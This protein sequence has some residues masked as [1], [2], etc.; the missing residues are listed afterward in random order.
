MG[1]KRNATIF[2]VGNLMKRYNLKTRQYFTVPK[3]G[4]FLEYPNNC[5]LDRRRVH[6]FV[7]DEAAGHL[8]LLPAVSYEERLEKCCNAAVRTE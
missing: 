4:G 3:E 8:P 1:G 7:R 6:H 2:P 5:Q